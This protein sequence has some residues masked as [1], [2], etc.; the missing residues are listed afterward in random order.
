MRPHW[1]GDWD[2]GSSLAWEQVSARQAGGLREGSELLP[3]PG[4]GWGWQDPRS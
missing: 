3:E 4:Q 1:P 2:P